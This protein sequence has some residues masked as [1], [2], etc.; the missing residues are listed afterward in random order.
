MQLC[1][2]GGQMSRL[3]TVVMLASMVLQMSCK[4]GPTEPGVRNPR[5]YRWSIDSLYIPT[6]QILL[7]SIWGSDNDLYAVGH[8]SGSMGTMWHFD[9]NGWRNV[10]LGSFE[11]GTIPAPFDLAAID[12]L[13]D[14]DIY[15]VGNRSPFLPGVSFII[16]YDGKQWTEQQVPPE[17]Y[18]LQ[19][20]WANGPNDVWTCGINGTLLHYDGLQWTK[21]SV[22]VATPS[23]STFYL[24]SIARI[25]TGEMFML[26]AAYEPGSLQVA[27]RW[28]YY[29]FRREGGQWKLVDTFVR[30]DSERVGK[31][32]GGGRLTVLPSGTMYSVDSYGVFQWSGTQWIR[33]YDNV[34]NTSQIFGTSDNNFFV[35]GTYG[36]LVHYNG[37]DWFQYSDLARQNALYTGGWADET[38]VFVLGWVDGEKTVVLR[39]K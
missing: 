16:H 28:T 35:T 11:G 34:N 7:A 38:Q 39:G 10:K 31:W 2:Q 18:F 32:G 33:R 21:D 8:S 15:A 14:H 36:L 22:V 13:N 4:K 19:A 25:P 12:G 24:S 5:D 30:N 9:G 23:G 37:A 20:V 29:F 1:E 26:G 27:E 3:C 17:S 6:Y